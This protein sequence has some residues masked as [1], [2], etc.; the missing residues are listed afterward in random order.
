MR[1]SLCSSE[2]ENE[3]YS[4]SSL[5]IDH[6]VYFFLESFRFLPSYDLCRD[7]PLPHLFPAFSFPDEVAC[8]TNFPAVVRSEAS[9]DGSV[10]PH[11]SLTHEEPLHLPIWRVIHFGASELLL[12]LRASEDQIR[13][14]SVEVN[15]TIP[16][17]FHHLSST[18]VVSFSAHPPLSSP[19]TYIHNIIYIHRPFTKV[20][21]NH[22]FTSLSLP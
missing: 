11:P 10:H 21:S 14:G 9:T 15:A 7:C 20:H 3:D 1:L 18:I 12:V 19:V 2:V 6:S 4:P 16:G 22:T 13:F 8:G 17:A 5:L